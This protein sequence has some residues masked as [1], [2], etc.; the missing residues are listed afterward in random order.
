MTLRR[1]TRR[2]QV[3]LLH[4]STQP[5]LTFPYPSCPY[6]GPFPFPSA[7]REVSSPLCSMLSAAI[8]YLT[9]HRRVH[10]NP[11]HA[12]LS[13]P[14]AC[15]SLCFPRLSYRLVYLAPGNHVVGCQYKLSCTYFLFLA[16]LV[17]CMYVY[18]KV[19]RPYNQMKLAAE[20]F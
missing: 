6:L 15:A 9:W 1:S 20:H 10:P 16:L 14:C 4:T 3:E 5:T 11:S 2:Y 18:G 19:S 7:S 12:P 17:R 13:S 8:L